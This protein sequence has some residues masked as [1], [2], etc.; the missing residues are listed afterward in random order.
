MNVS[1]KN[2]LFLNKTIKQLVIIFVTLCF[3]FNY[4]AKGQKIG[5]YVFN[6][7]FEKW[8]NCDP[9][10]NLDKAVG[11]SNLGSDSAKFGGH[12]Y[13]I[14]P[15]CTNAPYTDVGFQY[16]RTGD[17]FY[18]H[19][20][21]CVSPCSYYYSR[22]YPKNRMKANLEANKTYCV[23]MYA[24]RQ[25][26]CPYAISDFGFYF[27]DSTS[28][29]I[30]YSNGPITYLAPQVSNP[31]SNIIIDT[32]NWV[33]ISGTFVATGTEKYL[34]LGN[35]NSNAA[36]TSSL[37]DNSWGTGIW[38]E[39]FVD[40]ISC[41]EVN[42]PAYAGADKSVIP[43][44]SVY[45]GRELDFAVDSGCTWFKLPNTTTSIKKASGLWVKP[46]STSTYVVKQVLECSSEK[47]DTV[48]VYM[49]PLGIVS[50]SE[51]ENDLKLFPNPANDFLEL[52][53][54]DIKLTKDFNFLEIYNNLG[55]LIEQK[56]IYFDNTHLKIATDNFPNGVYFLRL[57]TANNET[58]ST[59]F[60]VAR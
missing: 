41:I 46:T 33:A 52:S 16:P 50:S 7:S 12:L 4:K 24:C 11:W 55:I 39:Y 49:N 8:Y 27:G 21:Y 38:A 19:G 51:V 37:V 32:L 9:P 30:K 3:L 15:G 36:T 53:M 35:F 17:K 28:D 10:A 45:I 2:W 26:D 59:R 31:V 56:E 1:Q 13:S 23:K 43:G 34:V 60:L 25:N 42:L 6:G 47:W 14:T 44:D 29:T 58:L 48:V 57:R 18:R 20:P 54:S 22:G 40:D 5:N